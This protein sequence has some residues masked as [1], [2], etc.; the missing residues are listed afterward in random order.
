MAKITITESD[1]RRM[2]FD[3]VKKLFEAVKHGTASGSGVWEPTEVFTD[4]GLNDD[5]IDAMIRKYPQ[6]EWNAYNI[7]AKVSST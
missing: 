5:E 2:V 1:I 3:G 7:T 4:S 6:I